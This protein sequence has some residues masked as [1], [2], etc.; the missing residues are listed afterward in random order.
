MIKTVK[1]K[2]ADRPLNFGPASLEEFED[3]T[4]FDIFQSLKA[5][6]NEDPNEEVE[7]AFLKIFSL[8]SLISLA[9]CGLKY[10][11]LVEGK[12]F[13]FTRTQVSLWFP[14]IESLVEVIAAFTDSMPQEENTE[15]EKKQSQVK[16]LKPSL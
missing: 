13:E 5:V 14:T 1:I 11:Q 15:E 8:K 3:L 10:G 16:E 7:N 2:G 6:Q 9:Y 12:E 4:G